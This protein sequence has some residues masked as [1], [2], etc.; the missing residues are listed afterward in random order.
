M[1]QAINHELINNEKCVL[2][3]YKSTC[4]TA[5]IPINCL[6]SGYEEN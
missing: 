6:L 4:G 3:V 2:A 5:C 1:I